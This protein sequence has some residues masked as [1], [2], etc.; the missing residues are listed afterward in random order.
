MD[1]ELWERFK[2]RLLKEIQY[3]EDVISIIEKYQ[4]QDR[5]EVLDYLDRLNAISVKY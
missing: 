2:D 4:L 5:Q 3:Q 1:K